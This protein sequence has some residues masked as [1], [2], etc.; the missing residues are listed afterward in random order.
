MLI[1]TIS[2]RAA[3]RPAVRIITILGFTALT[4]LAARATIV[5]PFTPVPV[6]LQVFAVLLAGLTLG[7][8]DGALSQVLY[9]G[10]I[11]GGLPI[12]ALGLGV[13]AWAQPTAGYLLGFIACAA[14][15]GYLAEQGLRKNHWLRFAAGIAGVLAIYLIG[16]AWLT[17]GFL[18]GDWAAGWTLGIAPFILIDLIKAILAAGLTEGVRSGLA[19]FSNS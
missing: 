9:L 2:S 1:H 5:L 15:S 6:T 17:Y 16:A 4:A 13:A 8:R 14:L 18:A 11:T 7:A 10:L 12:D 19:A 3:N